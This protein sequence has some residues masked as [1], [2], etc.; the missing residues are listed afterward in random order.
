M[1]AFR[2]VLITTDFS[3][4]SS[5]ALKYSNSLREL[6]VREVVLLHVVDSS[7]FEILRATAWQNVEEEIQMTAE[8]AVKEAS[9][10]IE[11]DAK[12]LGDFEVKS[13]VKFGSPSEE[14]VKIADEE[15]VDLVYMAERGRHWLSTRLLGDVAEEV[16]MKLRKP[17]MVVKFEVIEKNGR[18]EIKR[19][20][21]SPFE[22]ILYATDFSTTAERLKGIVKEMALL[23]G[24]KIV[25]VAVAE[26]IHHLVDEIEYESVR[27][28]AERVKEELE[29]AG[30]FV[31][32]YV[33][34][35]AAN[36][37]IE[38]IAERELPSMIAI[39]AV[40]AGGAKNLGRTADSVLRRARTTVFVYR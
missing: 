7:A 3:E 17:L 30:L 23:G 2:K 29:K 22:K 39:G 32:L 8:A 13:I 40:G 19:R 5:W 37:A 11:E 26:A 4:Y 16:A 20:F 35:G 6:G 34:R 24:R 33:D 36:R 27:E 21:D 38:R 18:K 31:R 1:S 9:R 10:R 28:K 14:I 12:L 25:L 15:N